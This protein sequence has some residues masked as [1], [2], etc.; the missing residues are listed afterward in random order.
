M[1]NI[2]LLP[3]NKKWIKQNSEGVL[4]IKD[5]SKKLMLQYNQGRQIVVVYFIEIH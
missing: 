2:K 3:H 4:L 5:Y 1:M